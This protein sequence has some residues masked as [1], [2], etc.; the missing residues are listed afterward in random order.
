MPTDHEILKEAYDAFNARDIERA[1]GTMHPQVDWQNG[2]EGGYV[3][4]HDGVRDY[5][6]RQW[7]LIDPHAEP[8]RF[9]TEGSGS[10]VVVDVH[11]IVRDLSGHVLMDRM[12]QHVYAIESGLIRRMKI[13][14]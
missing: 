13:R 1:L 14:T 9:A 6:S 3:H 5:W 8:Q 2:M 4:G 12:V 7:R 11:Q 10:V